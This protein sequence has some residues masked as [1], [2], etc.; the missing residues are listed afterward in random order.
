MTVLVGGS[1]RR[2][3]TTETGSRAGRYQFFEG[4]FFYIYSIGGWGGVIHDINLDFD[5]KLINKTLIH[6]V[7]SSDF[8]NSNN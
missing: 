1:R 7:Y 6:F 3:P 2:L 5:L 4:F 8:R